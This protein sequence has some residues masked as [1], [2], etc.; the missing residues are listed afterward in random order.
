M[1][2]YLDQP[3]HHQLSFRVVLPLE[4]LGDCI[5]RILGIED[6]YDTLLTLVQTELISFENQMRFEEFEAFVEVPDKTV[7]VLNDLRL[8]ITDQVNSL[9]P[10]VDHTT[11]RRF[12]QDGLDRMGLKAPT[13]RVAQVHVSI[14]GLIIELVKECQLPSTST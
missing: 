8:T 10:G 12:I 4:G 14:V 1:A 5:G 9:N 6:I 3:K 7:D 11:L 2:T 13:Y